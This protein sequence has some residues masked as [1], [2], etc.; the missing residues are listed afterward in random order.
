MGFEGSRNASPNDGAAFT[1]CERDSRVA[2][3]PQPTLQPRGMGEK[4]VNWRIH[5][6]KMRMVRDKTKGGFSRASGSKVAKEQ[7]AQAKAAKWHEQNLQMRNLRKKVKAG[8]NHTNS[9]K[10]QKMAKAK[11]AANYIQKVE[12]DFLKDKGPRR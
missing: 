10:A 1:S 11:K 6:M 2:R 3:Y 9:S 8:F 4:G 12:I 5:N 7:Q